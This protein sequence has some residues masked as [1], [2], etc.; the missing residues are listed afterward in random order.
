MYMDIEHL[1]VVTITSTISCTFG[2][3][4]HIITVLM[5]TVVVLL[6]CGLSLEQCH[7]PLL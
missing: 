5:Y 3:L 7:P 4:C 2:V 6:L 1:D